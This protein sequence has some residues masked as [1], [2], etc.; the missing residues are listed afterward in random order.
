MSDSNMQIN[1]V[2]CANTE[3]K[4]VDEPLKYPAWFWQ[5]DDDDD[6]NWKPYSNGHSEHIELS[7]QNYYKEMERNLY[8]LQKG[9]SELT[10][11]ETKCLVNISDRQYKIEFGNHLNVGPFRQISPEPFKVKRQVIR[12]GK[13]QFF[14]INFEQFQ[15]EQIV[16]EMN[17][18]LAKLNEKIEICK[19]RLNEITR[20]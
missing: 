3:T 6:E 2:D 17:Q 16:K 19:T 11:K 15:A 4:L 14:E 8:F 10:T 18:N 20:K 9:Q 12:I 13:N 1:V 5:D 7:Y